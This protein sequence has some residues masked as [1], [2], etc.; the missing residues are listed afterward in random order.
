MKTLAVLDLADN[1]IGD[2]GAEILIDGIIE[3]VYH[4]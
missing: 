4:T 1:A 2:E 3:K